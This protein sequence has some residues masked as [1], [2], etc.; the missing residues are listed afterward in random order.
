[1]LEL[2]DVR[3]EYDGRVVLHLERFAV[4]P[5]AAGEA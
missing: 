3:H 4:P 2:V 5:G 1:M